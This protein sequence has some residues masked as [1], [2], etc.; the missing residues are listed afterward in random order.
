VMELAL[1]KAESAVT[2]HNSPPNTKVVPSCTCASAAC[3]SYYVIKYRSNSVVVYLQGKQDCVDCCC[4]GMTN[5]LLQL[6]SKLNRN[7]CP[8]TGWREEHLLAAAG[9]RKKPCCLYSGDQSG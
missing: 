7:N 1:G 5:V 8:R 4:D 2:V 6:W 3:R 9:A